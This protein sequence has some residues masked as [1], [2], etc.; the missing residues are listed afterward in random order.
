MK[1]ARC[2]WS[3]TRLR[4]GAALALISDA[5]TPLVSDPGERL[6][7]AVIE[8]GLRIVPVPGASATLAALVGSGLPAHPCTILGFLPRKGRDRADMIR[9]ATGA[10]H[11]VVLFEAPGRVAD[12]LRDL[13]DVA[14]DERP[15]VVAR[16]LTKRFEEFRRGTLANS[17]R[18]TAMRLLAARS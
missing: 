5:G 8:A 12:T 6:V 18:T 7:H 16:E 4:E 3:S 13:A 1:R 11:A 15:V 10:P 14:G 2:R 9:W 17:P